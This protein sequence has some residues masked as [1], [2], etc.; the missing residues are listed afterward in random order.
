MKEKLSSLS[1]FRLAVVS[2]QLQVADVEGNRQK[3]CAVM[4]EC[5]T[6]NVQL[7]V[8]PELCIT[9]YTCA[10]LFYQHVLLEQASEATFK[11]A[12]YSAHRKTAI[13]VGVPLLV[14]GKLFNC[15]VFIS[16]GSILG[17]IPKTYLPNTQEF[18]EQRWFASE[19]DRTTTEII[20]HGQR[21]PFGRDLLFRCE[22]LPECIVGIEICE[23][24]WTP[25]P[26][27]NEMALQGATVIANLSASTELL[28][29]MEY[30]KLLVQSQS[31]R[32]LAA[33][34]YSSA[35]PG[36]SSTDLVFSGHSLIAENGAI[37]AETRRFQFESQIAIADIDI[38]RL[39]SE[40][41]KSRSFAQSPA[42]NS[43]RLIPF[44][45]CEVVSDRLYRT[46]SMRPFVPLQMEERSQKCKEI[47]AIQTTGLIKRMMAI[48]CRTAILGVSG[49]LDSTLALLATIKAFT[50]LKLDMK[51]IYAVTMPGFGTT[52]YSKNNAKQLAELLGV[53]LKEIP[54]QAAM[55]QHFK[56]IGHNPEVH[57]VTY[58]NAQARERTQI[59]MDLANQH[60][61][62]VIGTGDLSEL[63][64]GWCTYN[65]DHISMYAVNIGIPKT[66]VSYII[67]WC[68]ECEFTGAVANVLQDIVNAP[69]SPELLPPTGNNQTPQ[70]TEGT[71]GPYILHDFFL[72]YTIRFQYPPRK[73]AYLAINTFAEMYTPAEILRWMKL[74]YQRFFA[75]QFKRSCLPDGP[76]VGTVA[77]SP[78]GD[79]RMPSD[80]VGTVWLVD[81]Q[82]LEQEILK[83]G[84]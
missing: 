9:G 71:I 32:C 84:R 19:Y 73:I 34:A 78:R 61:G 79:W 21:I 26:P 46:V 58:E 55:E 12:A 39:I 18:Y 27:S 33:Y 64:L 47:F 4:D 24:L 25:T 31:G 81:L 65:G 51:N 82:R 76:K 60:G 7:I 28:G 75:H 17:V 15:A 45:T 36:E 48:G 53:T 14:F 44:T 23:D 77:L 69:V 37:L 57:D 43:L 20:W 49:G 16:Q 10:D 38:Q 3:I 40:R 74:F 6:Q 62:I 13:I 56:D 2:T 50:Q 70:T 8:F 59:L 72:Y 29:K 11:L 35:G 5:A 1:Y 52:D 67:Q 42:S 80:A 66:L 54:I 68:A 83:N 22:S 63:A 41:I 30:R